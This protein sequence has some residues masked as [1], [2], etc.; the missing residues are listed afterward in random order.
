M[1]YSDGNKLAG[2][3]YDLGTVTGVINQLSSEV[4]RFGRSHIT[5]AGKFFRGVAELA[6]LFYYLLFISSKN[7]RTKIGL[8]VVILL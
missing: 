2:R 3:I 5:A 6:V 8:P 1:N 4:L 7:I